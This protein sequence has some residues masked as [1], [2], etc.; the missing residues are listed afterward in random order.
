MRK[1][2][3]TWLVFIILL[4]SVLMSA[5]ANADGEAPANQVATATPI[6]TAPAVARPTYIVERGTVQDS[7]EFTGRWQPRDQ[8]NLS[9]EI[10][11]QVRRVEVRR[12]D[13]VS[14]GQLLADYEITSLE[15]QLAQAQL[16]LES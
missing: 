7:L 13:Q 12:G 3:L 4:V 16:D 1:P 11:G 6:P 9:F 5:C 14:A 8:L 10:A 15:N 2:V